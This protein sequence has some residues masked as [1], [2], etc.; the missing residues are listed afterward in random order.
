[1]L[2]L[3]FKSWSMLPSLSQETLV[4]FITWVSAS[5]SR[6]HLENNRICLSWGIDALCVLWAVA[7]YWVTTGRWAET[8][9]N[10]LQ[11]TQ[12][13]R[14][15]ISQLE[16]KDELYV[17]SSSRWLPRISRR[18]LG[19]SQPF[20]C[21]GIYTAGFSSSQDGSQKESEKTRNTS[22]KTFVPHGDAQNTGTHAGCHTMSHK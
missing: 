18:K 4:L 14:A 16:H 17:I 22:F 15:I 5:S 1:M 19:P 10:R 8:I 6:W 7:L 21:W 9:W 11:L 2:F 12:L 13:K 3:L 20:L